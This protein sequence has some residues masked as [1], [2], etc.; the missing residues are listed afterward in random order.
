MPFDENGHFRVYPED[1]TELPVQKPAKL[2]HVIFW[3]TMAGLAC[4]AVWI[5]IST[6]ATWVDLGLT[7]LVGA[8]IF[9]VFFVTAIFWIA[10]HPNRRDDN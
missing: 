3:L 6:T 9:L 4:I 10:W 8:L 2:P 5:V 1:E 7:I